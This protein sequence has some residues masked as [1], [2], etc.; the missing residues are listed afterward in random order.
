M[1]RGRPR[2]QHSIAELQALIAE[3]RRNRGKLQTERKK[4][5]NRLDQIDR[6]IAMLDGGG[7]GGGGGGRGGR[8][9]SPL[10]AVIEAV[11]KKSGKPMRVGEI[12]QAVQAAGYR[13]ASSNFRGIVNQALI[14]EKKRFTSPA[15]GQ[16]SLK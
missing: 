6:Q 13:S 16:Y 4:L 1:P 8:N 2:K 10:P 7:V 14:K 15:R 11:L 3:Q 5:Q 9:G 12:A